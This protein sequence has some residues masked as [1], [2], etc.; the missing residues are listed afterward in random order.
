[1]GIKQIVLIITCSFL[2]LTAT[3][4]GKKSSALLLSDAKEE[5]L[6]AEF[7]QQLLDS[8]DA[9]PVFNPGSDSARL[10]LKNYLD[11]VFHSVLIAVDDLPNYDK[12]FT[13]TIIDQDVVN[14]FAVPGGYI[15]I[16]TGILKEMQ[17]ESE[18]AGVIGHEI[19]HVTQHHYRQAVAKMTIYSTLVEALI[20]SDSDLANF[21][22]GTFNV[23][24]G[25]YV[26]RDHEYEADEYGTKYLALSD[27]NPRGIASFFARM[28]DG[29]LWHPEMLSTHPNPEKRVEEV[30]NQVDNNSAWN[31]IDTDEFKYTQ[32]YVDNTAVLR[33]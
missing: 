8:A 33:Q 4:C 5:E 14:A 3:T 2:V 25:S 11:N 16:Y 9:F 13:F 7:H 29:G 32:K 15:Y 12:E 18:L 6:G 30:N 19:A 21:V 20:G 22:K 1:M 10:A 23:L 28:G 27:R 26:S 17:D 31:E 24:A